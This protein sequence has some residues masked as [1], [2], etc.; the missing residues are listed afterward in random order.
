VRFYREVASSSTGWSCCKPVVLVTLGG[1]HLLDG[2]VVVS[3]EA[4]KKLV[5]CSREEIVRGIVLTPREPR[6]A[7]LVERVVDLPSLVG[8]F[9]RC[10]MCGLG[11]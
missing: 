7:T 1:C 11:E 2:L 4:C 3:I 9:L 10:S 8:R 6:R 5:H